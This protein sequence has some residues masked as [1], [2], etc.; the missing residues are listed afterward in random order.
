M[1]PTE[2]VK[3]PQ[4]AQHSSTL[5]ILKKKKYIFSSWLTAQTA[6]IP[7][8]LFLIVYNNYLAFTQVFLIDRI[9]A[10]AS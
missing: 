6:D 10:D 9:E 7:E 8:L 2:F 1:E 3:Y 4:Y 5:L